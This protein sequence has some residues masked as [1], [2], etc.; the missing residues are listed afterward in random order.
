MEERRCRLRIN[1]S[2]KEVRSTID[3][4]REWTMKGDD[5]RKECQGKSM[6]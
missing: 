6:L 1:L 5:N 2:R 3:D 4:K